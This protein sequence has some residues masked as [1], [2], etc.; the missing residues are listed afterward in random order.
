MNKKYLL[1][2]I[3]PVVFIIV[4]LLVGCNATGNGSTGSGFRGEIGFTN[5]WTFEDVSKRATDIV[6]VEF[7]EKRSFGQSAMEF[8]FIVHE[9]V[10]GDAADRIFVYIINDNNRFYASH[11]LSF[12]VGTQYLL[13]LDRV[14]D[15]YSAFHQDGFFFL[16]N[17]IIDLDAP[18]RSTMNNE[19][20]TQHSTGINFNSRNL[21]RDAIVSYVGALSQN[22]TLARE[23][24]WSEDLEKIITGSPYVLTLDIGKPRRLASEGLLPEIIYTDIYYTTIVEVLYGDKRVGEVGDTLRVIFFGDTVFSGERHT[25]SIEPLLP[26]DTFFYIFTSP[27]SL[28]T[29]DQL[30][31]I[32][33][34]IERQQMYPYLIPHTD[35]FIE[36]EIRP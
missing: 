24:I 2:S 28:H 30:P 33:Q 31:E 3:T 6:V 11:E 8:E 34:I 26:Q 18:V 5:S 16:E 27:H 17:I 13:L 14:V 21:T 20:L 35:A 22:N 9:R 32:L 10:F 36:V 4:L 23:I 12:T 15:V 29:E 7:V 19:P 25:V 1:S